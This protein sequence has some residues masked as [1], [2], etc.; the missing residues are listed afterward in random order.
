MCGLTGF[1]QPGVEPGRMLED[2]RAMNDALLHRGPDD[3]GVWIDEACGIAL[4]HRRLSIVDLSA[5]GHQPM[6]SASGRYVISFNGEIYNFAALR[7]ELGREA[8]IDAWRGHSDTEVMLAAFDH[9]GVGEALR[10]LVGMF[11]IALWD[12]KQHVLQL[13]RDRFGEKPLYYGWMGRCFLFGSELKAL[14][15]HPAFQPR[16]DRNAFALYLRYGCIPA[17]DSIYVGIRK[18]VPGTLLSLPEA[19]LKAK[20]EVEARPYWSVR[21]ALERGHRVPFSGSDDAAVDALAAVLGE[22][23]AGQMVADVPLGAFLSGGIDSSTVV[24]LMQARSSRPIKTFSIGFREEAYDEAAAAKRVAQHLG[25]QHTELYVAPREALEVVPQVATIYDEP[26][27]DSSQIPTYLVSRLARQQVTVS[28]SGDGGDELFGGYNRYIWGTKL[29]QRVGWLPVSLRSLARRAISAVPPSSWDNLAASLPGISRHKA[30]GDKLHKL[31]R[32]LDAT[33]EG[34]LYDRLVSFWPARAG[35]TQITAQPGWTR[36]EPPAF[37]PSL[38][39]RMMYRDALGY[40]P[41]DILV[42]V[43]RAAMATSLETRVP[44]LDHRVFEFAASLPL[45]YKIRAGQSKWIV[46]QLLY[47]YVPR[48]LVERPKMGFAIPIDSWL[49]GPLREWAEDLLDEA[50][51]SQ[52][53]LF[54]VT[55]VRACWHAHQSGGHNWQHRLWTVVMFQAWLQR[56]SPS[57]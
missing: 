21:G 12:R 25:T 56:W 7:V 45:R 38:A 20:A 28:L 5:E 35:S 24:A 37:L 16:I 31:G 11:A 27:A 1:W 41:D 46:R 42:K 17:P 10:R 48:E 51:L 9:W 29:Q 22:S 8:G 39:E 19:S 57:A 55:A 4:G 6:T 2:V 36:S 26:F 49:R 23:V 47:R 50:K 43:D 18:L 44:F 52:T 30:V 40:L 54:D 33:T 14:R 53:G 32:L 34:E 15:A 3:G 13:V